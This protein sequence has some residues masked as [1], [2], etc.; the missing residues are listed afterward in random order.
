MEYLSSQF[1]RLASRRGRKR[2]ILA[3]AHS[4]LVIAY[5]LIDRG[6]DYQDLGMDYFERRRPDARLKYL[7]SQLLQLGYEVSLTARP[8]P[9]AA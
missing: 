4:I 5:H 2:A 8:Q 7:T 1:R 3:V 9:A 6:E